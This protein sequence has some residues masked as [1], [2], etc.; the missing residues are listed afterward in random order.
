MAFRTKIFL[1]V[2]VGALIVTAIPL[3]Y[4]RLALHKDLLLDAQEHA[5]REV[6]LAGRLYTV[7]GAGS[8]AR[9]YVESLASPGVRFS[10]LDANGK[11]IDDS[12]AP[13]STIPSATKF[14]DRPEVK[15]A[16][17]QGQGTATRFHN[18]KQRHIIYAATQLKNGEI[19]RIAMP[20]SG[21]TS[22][23]DSIL[24]NFTVFL[25][26]AIAL[27]LVLAFFISGLLRRDI[28]QM[29]RVIEAIS[30]GKYKRRLRYV[31]GKEFAPLAN[32]VNRMA[33]HIEEHIRTVADQKEQLQ[34][35]LD[36][37]DEG[38]LVFDQ[39]GGI[40]RC[41]RALREMFPNTDKTGQQVVEAIPVPALQEA[42]EEVLCLPTTPDETHRVGPLQLELAPGHTFSVHLTRAGANQLD[43]GAVAVFHNITAIM[44]LER[45]R[46]DFVANVSHELRTPLTAIQGY[47]ET[48]A[49]LED[50]PPSCRR[51]AEII[52][53]NGSYLARMLEELIALARLE[54]TDMPIQV[55]PV[56]IQE[57]ITSA[58]NLCRHIFEMRHIH[59]NTEVDE[60]I[61]VMAHGQHIV[62]VFRNLL[63]NA[64]RYAPEGGL[65]HIKAI[66]QN[67]DTNLLTC[68]ICDDGIGIPH[69]EHDRIFER[70]YRVEKHRGQSNNGVSTTNGTKNTAGPTTGLGLAICKHTVER[71]G[72]RIW[73]ESPSKEHATAFYFTL[74]LA[75]GEKQ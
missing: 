18:L 67:T 2:L 43:L 12:D 8:T 42:V 56:R 52:Q 38:V 24:T 73:V 14:N 7:M 44:R 1:A 45:I 3:L 64:G 50:M 10:L 58:I 69:T 27:S 75:S 41:N 62:Q 6:Q 47:A 72:G 37:M 23:M 28:A 26:A 21:I 22:H 29:I 17:T 4:A 32:A 16:Q 30:L 31:P 5:L 55:T 33:A 54:N 68:A 39:N 9:D 59:L 13:E 74:P 20:F 70:F 71:F 61:L 19:L 11:L 65:I 36:T 66:R 40:R 35:I 49:G 48:L 25:L 53:K 34:S 46:S 57:C 51:F 63:E 60:S 15:A